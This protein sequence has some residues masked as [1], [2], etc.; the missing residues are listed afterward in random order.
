MTALLERLARAPFRVWGIVLAGLIMTALLGQII[1][2]RV[3]ILRDG[4]EVRLATTPVDPRD[5]FRGDYVILTYEISNLVL[6]QLTGDDLDDYTEGDTVYVSLEEDTNGIWQASG[7]ARNADAF[8][9]DVFIKGRIEWMT[10][11]RPVAGETS[12]PPLTQANG[13]PCRP[14]NSARIAYGIESYFVPEGTGRDLE[15]MRDEGSVTVITAI[16]QNGTA[17]IKGLILDGGDPV[18]LEPL[19]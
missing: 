9:D 10:Q 18:Y 6:E 8:T 1:M 7:I 17:A 14:C 5:I 19:L 2:E 11:V 16:A 12:E 3:A 4:T 13:E 15:N